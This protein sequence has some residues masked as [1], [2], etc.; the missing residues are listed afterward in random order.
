[1]YFNFTEFDRII[2]KFKLN[3]KREEA[4]S[5]VRDAIVAGIFNDLG[6]GN[7]VDICV[8]TK[9][10]VDYMRSFEVACKKDNL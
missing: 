3:F 6:S 7:N 9:D 5:L 8:I 10:K 2:I 1:M 4:V